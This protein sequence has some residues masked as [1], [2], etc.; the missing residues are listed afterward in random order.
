MLGTIRRRF[1]TFRLG[2]GEDGGGV[3]RVS[4]QWFQLCHFLRC[5][6]GSGIGTLSVAKEQEEPPDR[7]S[8]TFSMSDTAVQ[9]HGAVAGQHSVV[10]PLLPHAETD[11]LHSQRL[12]H[13]VK[14]SF[15]GVTLRIR[16]SSDA[17][18]E[19]HCS[20]PSF[21][22]NSGE[23][24]LAFG[25]AGRCHHPTPPEATLAM[26]RRGVVG[27]A[28]CPSSPLVPQRRL[29]RYDHC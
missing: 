22:S 15:H 9:P 10:P 7:I 24:V 29:R 13:L 14:T 20:V 8:E 4:L 2:F 11:N 3:G 1:S 25:G 12:Y 18:V 16:F 6:T 26:V 5:G 28:V 27:A 23:A 21:H 17:V 19:P